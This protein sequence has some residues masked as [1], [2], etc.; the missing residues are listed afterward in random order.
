VIVR[1]L[2]D[3]VQL[4]TQPDHAHLAR[5]IMEHCVPLAARPR[6]DA[7]LH[8]IDEHD[9]GW[10]EEDAAPTVDPRT[11]NVVDFVSA[12]VHVRHAVWPR[13]IARLADDAWAAALVAQHALTVYDRFRSDAEWTSFFAEIE[14]TRGAMLGAS[15]LPLNDLL[16]D[17]AFVR[18]ADLTSLAF[19]TGSTDEQ[20]FGDWTIQLSG[21]RVVVTPDAFGAAEIPIEVRAR[22]VRNHPFRSDRELRDAL[23]EAKATT[24]RGEVAGTRRWRGP[25]AA[26]T[27]RSS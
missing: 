17:Y 27:D 3:A 8:A 5:A 15:A 6:R 14:T 21:T 22:R 24:L 12:P 1:P 16:A 20:R 7:I 2:P 4:I 19:C 10:A 23:S 9:N 13:A 26:A 11:G 25:D 18:L